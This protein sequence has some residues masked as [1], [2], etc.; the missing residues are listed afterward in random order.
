MELPINSAMSY[1]LRNTGLISQ[2]TK[3]LDSA[4]T[5]QDT[6]PAA[7]QLGQGTRRSSGTDG[8]K[9]RQATAFLQEP[10]FPQRRTRPP[11]PR[12]EA[13][14]ARREDQ[15]P[16]QRGPGAQSAVVHVP[17]GDTKYQRNRGWPRSHVEL[18]AGGQSAERPDR[19]AP[20]S[21][22]IAYRRHGIL[23]PRPAGPAVTWNCPNVWLR[24]VRPSRWP[25]SHVELP[26]TAAEPQ[27]TDELAPQ[28]HGIALRKTLET[29]RYLAG[30]AGT[31]NC[32]T[33][34]QHACGLSC[35]LRR[36]MD[37]PSL[38]GL[39][40]DPRKSAPQAHGFALEA[41]LA[42]KEAEAG[43]AGGLPV[44]HSHHDNRI[45]Q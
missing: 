31:W 43:P 35:W 26:S 42:E 36:H 4:T 37:L 2:S 45:L 14:P 10:R 24:Y 15:G 12:H 11:P 41:L 13:F 39:T 18:P 34:R 23:L 3:R 7:G 5:K 29:T 22:G 27:E 21:R 38:N 16:E 19:L 30:P 20:Q 28:A 17:E 40:S 8:P 32:P 44:L 9:G 1:K 6:R 25:R 33:E